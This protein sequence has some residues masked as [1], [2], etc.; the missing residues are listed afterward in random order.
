MIHRGYCTKSPPITYHRWR[1]RLCILSQETIHNLE[2][3]H[4]THNKHYDK[5]SISRFDQPSE[6]MVFS[7]YKDEEDEAN[8]KPIKKFI[9]D[10]SWNSAI[11]DCPM[12]VHNYQH[13]IKLLLGP[14]YYDREMF[15]CVEDKTEHSD[16]LSA[17]DACADS[18]RLE[19]LKMLELE[20]NV[21]TEKY[22]CLPTSSLQVEHD[23][24]C[25]SLRIDFILPS[26]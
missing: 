8:N 11:V 10:T 6:F 22:E 26:K 12:G 3:F 15:L 1:R 19:T 23:N 5:R 20:L 13:V 21:P 24:F 25:S 16:W 14:L 2:E 7:Y 4:N 18:G 17:F 9:I